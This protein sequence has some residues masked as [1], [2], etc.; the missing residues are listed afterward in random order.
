MFTLERVLPVRIHAVAAVVCY[1]KCCAGDLGAIDAKYDIAV[2]TSCAALDYIVVDTTG[3]AQCCV[4]MLRRK[5]L[6]VATFLILDKQQPLA[7][8]L[9][10]KPSPPE[11]EHSHQLLQL[12]GSWAQSSDTVCRSLQ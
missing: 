1:C 4:E 5:G 9:Q 2:S 7:K 3:T 8:A 11:G 6:G 10:E 12:H